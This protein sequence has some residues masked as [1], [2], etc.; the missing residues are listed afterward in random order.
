MRTGPGRPFSARI[1][2]LIASVSAAEPGAIRPSAVVIHQ[3]PLSTA[4]SSHL[5][6]AAIKAGTA[7]RAD[8]PIRARAYAASSCR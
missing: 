2:R 6:Y 1:S 7:P 4:P 8:V 3:P 5:E